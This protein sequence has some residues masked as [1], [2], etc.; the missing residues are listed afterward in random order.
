MQPIAE[1]RRGGFSLRPFS[2]L[3][4]CLLLLLLH[5]TPPPLLFADAGTISWTDSPINDDASLV[6]LPITTTGGGTFN[7]PFVPAFSRTIADYTLLV[8][9]TVQFASFSPNVRNGGSTIRYTNNANAVPFVWQPVSSGSATGPDPLVVGLTVFIFEISSATGPGQFVSN[10]T[11]AITRKASTNPF[12]Q[13][14]AYSPTGNPPITTPPLSFS[15]G[16]RFQ[17]TMRAQNALSSIQFTATDQI[18]GTC[19]MCYYFGATQALWTNVPTCTPMVAGV[20]TAAIP[21][22]VP[23][24]MINILSIA[25]SG[26]QNATYSYNI[27]RDPSTIATLDALTFDPTDPSFTGEGLE[28]GSV[29]TG[30]AV[31]QESSNY[32]MNVSNSVDRIRMF[33][34]LTDPTSAIYFGQRVNGVLQ[35]SSDHQLIPDQTWAPSTGSYAVSTSPLGVF[36]GVNTFNLSI[37]AQDG[38]TW[39]YYFVRIFRAP[40]A[41]ARVCSVG[42]QGPSTGQFAYE[43]ASTVFNSS[44]QDYALA[45]VVFTN[46]YMYINVSLCDS[47]AAMVWSRRWLN[48]AVVDPSA[49]PQTPWLA[50]TTRTV[51][52]VPLGVGPNQFWV[53]VMAQ[54]GFTAAVYSWNVTRLSG[55]ASL[56]SFSVSAVPAVVPAPVFSPS[57]YF[58]TATTPNAQTQ[59]DSF[60][61][62]LN[63]T[64][65]TMHYFVTYS[66]STAQLTDTALYIPLASGAVAPPVPLQIGYTS[67]IVV[68]T[69]QD[70]VPANTRYYNLTIERLANDTTLAALHVYPSAGWF[71]GAD[72]SPAFDGSI[73][74]YS[75]RV[76]Y[77]SWSIV[78]SAMPVHY[79]A[80]VAYSMLYTGLPASNPATLSYTS[81]GSGANSTGLGLHTGFNYLYVQVTAQDLT[82]TWTEIKLERITIDAALKA[83]VPLPA[84]FG[85]VPTFK[86]NTL[87]YGVT[88]LPAV[89]ALELTPV[90]NSSLATIRWSASASAV[91][92]MLSLSYAAIASGVS[93]GPIPLPVG[94]TY[95]YFEVVAQESS[96]TRYYNVTL[97]RLSNDT[98]LASLVLT[99]SS[100][101][102]FPLS[103]DFAPGQLQ[104]SLWVDHA[105]FT[106]SFHATPVWYSLAISYALRSYTPSGAPA[107]LTYTPLASGV[108]S[109]NLTLVTGW[110]YLYIRTV[111]EDNSTAFVRADI[112][113]ISIDSSLAALTTAPVGFGLVPAFKPTILNYVVFVAP[114]VTQIALKPTVNYTTT[115]GSNVSWAANPTNTDPTTLLYT[116]VSSG[117]LSSPAVFLEIGWTVL[118]L[119][120]TAEDNFTTT[121]TNVSVCR[122][123]ND[124]TLQT[125]MLFDQFAYIGEAAFFTPAFDSAVTNYTLLSLPNFVASF[126]FSATPSHFLTAI[127]YALVPLYAVPPQSI[128]A[129]SFTPLQPGVNSTSIPL[130]AAWNYLFIKSVAQDGTTQFTS[131]TLQRISVD[132][133]LALI[134]TSPPGQ[135]GGLNPPFDNAQFEYSLQFASTQ[136]SITVTA[137]L[138]FTFGDPRALISFAQN[139]SDPLNFGTYSAVSSGTPTPSLT[140]VDGTQSVYI[141]VIAQDGLATQLYNLSIVRASND[142]NLSSLVV[143][144]LTAPFVPFA[145]DFQD[146]L[147]NYSMVVHNDCWTVSLNL[148]PHY[149]LA[150][151]YWAYRYNTPAAA[152]WSLPYVLA[153]PGVNTT[154][155]VL[156]TGDTYIYVKCVAQDLTVLFT[157]VYVKRQSIDASLKALVLYPTPGIYGVLI[158]SFTPSRLSYT[159]IYQQGT[160]QLKITA[161]LNSTRASLSYVE[162]P[163]NLAPDDVS[164]T[165]LPIGS[166]VTTPY[167]PNVGNLV[168]GWNTFLLR[169]VAD[170]ATVVQY[171]NITV[172]RMSNE[173]RIAE[174]GLYPSGS[175]FSP[176]TPGFTPGGNAYN[177][178]VSSDSWTIQFEVTPLYYLETMAWS[179][180]RTTQPTNAV[181]NALPFVPFG[182]G[183][184]VTSPILQTGDTFIYIRVLSEASAH[185][186]H[187]ACDA[188]SYSM[189]LFLMPCIALLFSSGYHQRLQLHRDPSDA[190]QHGCVRLEPR[191]HCSAHTH[192]VPDLACLLRHA[193]QLRCG[194]PECVF[195]NKNRRREELHHHWPI[196]RPRFLDDVGPRL[197]CPQRRTSM[198][199]LW[200][201]GHLRFRLL[202][203]A[204]RL[205]LLWSVGPGRG[206]CHVKLL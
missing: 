83:L 125:L 106:L 124:S 63:T 123:S 94:F 135:N 180:V 71:P 98:Q 153:T 174:L 171:V 86:P 130:A 198:A 6:S 170:D 4:A 61:A 56:T 93:T 175:I 10:Y 145:P 104:Y 187:N 25:Q 121:F 134:T 70:Q 91:S 28:S 129:G 53:S 34:T 44:V 202:Q 197:S 43:D 95:V 5:A 75:G 99:P 41:D 173:N 14:L 133:T 161:T 149:P 73:W 201:R 195:S 117:Q 97:K 58:F 182:A 46:V 192:G 111:A 163:L 72:L 68:V 194:D 160:A 118:H 77:D 191:R 148:V 158:P 57:K 162:N 140:L 152:Y 155:V 7:P 82:K 139:P 204:R 31:L 59:L 20:I 88:V 81:L 116:P 17:Y 48:P 84:G 159:A 206:R 193:L 65:A 49:L 55:D 51:L 157:R 79:L 137:L 52:S 132:A 80:K 168:I 110:S 179:Y 114:I 183:V 100:Q 27:T 205:D 189:T 169:V 151:V 112:R 47:T 166:G 177:L 40:S 29:V 167:L 156:V 8:A 38:V 32:V 141:H 165:Y 146:G 66:S 122:M 39:K 76:P 36:V 11:I 107:G 78:F 92:D 64:L 103:P 136:A 147:F 113:R 196:A 2:L 172:K 50:L 21:V 126:I 90:A 138:N 101:T 23:W 200:K 164:L 144:T 35:T 60:T 62:V 9:N 12:I 102:V 181:R 26:I 85:M 190:G 108:E 18:V 127:S 185:S 105:S 22:S 15:G 42:W 142:A 154:D 74:S 184:N 87:S 96:A 89:T 3:I 67:V 1:A 143:N 69:A 45:P 203:R 186:A 30:G 188:C 54:D 109:A 33:P 199:N 37:L 150:T 119:R 16:S 120:V 13:T 24:T 131:V 176:M 178:F 19:S 128:P 115:M